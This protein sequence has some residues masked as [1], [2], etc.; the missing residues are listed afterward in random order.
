MKNG[1]RKTCFLLVCLCFV[2]GSAVGQEFTPANTTAD[3]VTA[4]DAV[5]VTNLVRSYERTKQKWTDADLLPIAIAYALTGHHSE[6]EKAYLAYLK[7]KPKDPR[8]LRGLAGVYALQKR[9]AD[10][11]ERLEMAW[12]LKDDE[13]LPLLASLYLQTKQPQ[14][15]KEL[16]PEMLQVRKDAIGKLR[17]NLVNVL[18]YVAVNAEPFDKT[19]FEKAI[20]GLTDGEIVAGNSGENIVEGLKQ[21]GDITR[22]ASLEKKLAAKKDQ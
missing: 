2:G 14:K 21:L 3:K 11:V 6:S 9:Y 16:V 19:T 1:F 7:V 20:D 4:M 22:A 18:T 17:N 13:S 10:A 15:C 8:G 12:K 5:S